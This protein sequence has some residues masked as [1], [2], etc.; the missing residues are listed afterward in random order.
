M[1]LAGAR[2]EILRIFAANRIGRHW[3]ELGSVAHFCGQKNWLG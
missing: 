1:V 2:N 3:V